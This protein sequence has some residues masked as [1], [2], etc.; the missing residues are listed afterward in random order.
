M[1]TTDDDVKPDSLTS[2]SED[3]PVVPTD[4]PVKQAERSY[5]G[6]AASVDSESRLSPIVENYLKRITAI[7]V[8]VIF[9]SVVMMMVTGGRL[10]SQVDA[11]QAATLSLTKRVV[12]M[13]SAL[14]Q[15]SVLDSKLELLDLGHASLI[16]SNTEAGEAYIE[17]TQGF[18]SELS[19][20]EA[21]IIELDDSALNVATQI[22]DIAQSISG[23]EQIVS[24]VLSRLARLERQISSLKG[25]ERDIQVLVEIE[26]GNLKELFRQQLALEQ[27]KVAD[28]MPTEGAS[29]EAQKQQ[30]DGV[31]TYSTTRD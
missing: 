27:R 14:E 11:L 4:K 21:T 3:N 24:D 25:L 30:L 7:S 26:Q 5:E 1:E 12:N 23:Q 29:E 28:K 8:G 9:L 20:F 6:R 15:V 18:S 13:N 19:K 16:D 17:V 22:S 10:A 31:V 2:E